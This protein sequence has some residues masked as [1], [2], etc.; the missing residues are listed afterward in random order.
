MFLIV[1]S[2]TSQCRVVANSNQHHSHGMC[3]PL[4]ALSNEQVGA[5]VVAGIGG[6]AL[7]KLRAAGVKVLLA[8]PGSAQ[9]LLDAF[10]AGRLAEPTPNH[11]CGGHQHGLGGC[12]HSH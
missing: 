7:A 3:Q 8:Q 2:D 5:V 12:G 9:Q 1:D 6:G 10:R 11:V 4:A